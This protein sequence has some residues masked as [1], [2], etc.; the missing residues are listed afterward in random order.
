MY[1][2]LGTFNSISTCYF[3]L[4]SKFVLVMYEY[5]AIGDRLYLKKFY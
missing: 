5:M 1:K 2:S 3:S 4:P